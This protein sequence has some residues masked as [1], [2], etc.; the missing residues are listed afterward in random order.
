MRERPANV[1][2]VLSDGITVP[3]AD[4][5][6]TLAYSN[7]VMEHL[8]PD[9]AREQLTEIV[10]C[11]SPGGRYLCVTPHRASG[12]HDISA[13]FGDEPRGFHLK[14]YSVGEL[15]AAFRESGFAHVSAHAYVRGRAVRIPLAVLRPLKSLIFRL[16]PSVRRRVTRRQPLRVLFNSIHL[17]GERASA[18]EAP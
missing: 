3:I 6:V 8:H 13:F 14:E 2:L 10:R 12:P 9:D 16:P 11:L 4:G 5:C 7:Q 18:G 17:L 1:E 15:A